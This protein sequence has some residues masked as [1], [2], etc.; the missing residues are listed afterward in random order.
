MK[1]LHYCFIM[2]YAFKK[3][4]CLIQTN[5]QKF[6]SFLKF[7]NFVIRSGHTLNLVL[8]QIAAPFSQ[9]GAKIKK[10]GWGLF[11]LHQG[12]RAK[13]QGGGGAIFRGVW[14]LLFKHKIQLL[15]FIWALCS[16]GIFSI[17]LYV[18]LNFILN[19]GSFISLLF[20]MYLFSFVS[21]YC[22]LYQLIS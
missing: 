17:C 9:G 13:T 15:K 6:F 1:I 12:G 8:T 4:N 18:S 16:L 11:C 14:Q 7:L 5:S 20:C 3:Q 21:F 22:V 10:V 19:I 2:M